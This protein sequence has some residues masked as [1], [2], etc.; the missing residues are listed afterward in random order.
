MI[1]AMSR[2]LNG[3]DAISRIGVVDSMWPEI[4]GTHGL[5]RLATYCV[6]FAP[7]N[8]PAGLLE[9]IRRMTAA[10]GRPP[11][12]APIPIGAPATDDS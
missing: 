12:S 11:R 9:T 10:L 3:S 1:P 2:Q 4:Y 6:D 5:G 8:H 7:F